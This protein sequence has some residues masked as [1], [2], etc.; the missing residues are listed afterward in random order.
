MGPTRKCLVD[1]GVIVDESHKPILESSNLDRKALDDFCR[2]VVAFRFKPD[3]PTLAEVA[4][5]AAAGTEAEDGDT[6]ADQL[7]YADRGPQLFDFSKLRRASE[8]IMF[9]DRPGVD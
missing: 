4:A 3:E 2:R 6:A 9:C 7:Q 1:N 8:G 5:E